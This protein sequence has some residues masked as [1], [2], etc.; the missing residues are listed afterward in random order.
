[1]ACSRARRLSYLDGRPGTLRM[2]AVY[3]GLPSAQSSICELFLDCNESQPCQHDGEI[4]QCMGCGQF[5]RVDPPRWTVWVM[6]IKCIDRELTE[7]AGRGKMS[8][9]HFEAA[10]PMTGVFDL[11]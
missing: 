8:L 7:R 1:M 6:I 11:G 2:E 5:S 4:I 10:K 3:F 9:E